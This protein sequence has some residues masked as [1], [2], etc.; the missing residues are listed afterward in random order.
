VTVLKAAH[1]LGFDDFKFSIRSGSHTAHSELSNLDN[2]IAIWLKDLN[3]LSL[4]EDQSYV[5]VGPGLNTSDIFKRL[6]EFN[7]T[8]VGANH[9]VGIAGLILSGLC[10][11]LQLVSI[12]M[13]LIF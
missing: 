7:M 1:S 9:P 5:S 4:S 2:G 12:T 13:T 8:I 10:N 3:Q 6:E 11:A